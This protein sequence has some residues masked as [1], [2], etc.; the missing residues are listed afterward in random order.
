MDEDEKAEE[1]LEA[2]FRGQ[3]LP[4]YVLVEIYARNTRRYNHHVI[5]GILNETLCVNTCKSELFS[6]NNTKWNEI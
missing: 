4:F 5:L 1:I 6:E 3:S 2:F